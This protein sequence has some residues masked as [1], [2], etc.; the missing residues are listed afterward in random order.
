VLSADAVGY[1]R[2][3]GEDE[4]ATIAA[5]GAARARFRER[6]AGRAGRVVD[7]AGDNVL[8]VFDSVIEALRAAI[9]I[10]EDLGR[11]EENVPEPRRMRFRIG[12]NAGEIVEEEDGSVYGDG[13]N[14]A[15]RLQALAEP[16]GIC[17]AEVVAAQ[18]RNKL[19]VR[20]ESLGEQ[21]VKNIAEPIRPHRVI[22]SESP[23]V[24]ASSALSL[25]AKPSIA[26]LPFVNMS[27][28]PE[29]EYFSDGIS[30]DL[31]TALSRIRWFFVVARNSSFAYKSARIDVKQVGRELGVRYVLEGS[32]RKSGSR[33]RIT[34]QPIDASSG[35]H[36]WAERYDR[37]LADV[38]SL[39]DEITNRISAAIEP[40]LARAEVERSRRKAPE[41]LDAWDFYQR[42][43]W[44]LWQFTARDNVLARGFFERAT[45]L[46]SGFSTFFAALALSRLLDHTLGYRPESERSVDAALEAA[47]RAV[48]LD[49]KDPGAHSALGRTYSVLGQ[50]DEGIAELR[51]ALQLNPSMALARYGLGVALVLSGRAKEAV[52]EFDAAQRLSP[53]DV[54]LWNFSMWRAWAHLSLGDFEHAIEDASFSVRQPMAAFPA[55]GTLASAL[56]HAGR[57]EEARSA[58]AKT[59][60]LEPRFSS[61]QFFESVWPNADPRLLQRIYDGLRKLDPTIPDPRAIIA[62]RSRT[63]S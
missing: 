47:R 30:E 23:A 22:S 41:N 46:D 63:R 40:E 60:E 9:E 10:Q 49:E 8:A 53:H 35:N 31:I 1:S 56:A 17:A 21:R 33:V 61:P 48:A 39:Q 37:E 25:P 51:R 19:P 20:F 6:I 52:S 32:V 12:V 5:L 26:V 18:V 45:E 11:L 44:H 55:W 34:A 16:G 28:D 43:V 57:L 62:A 36:V 2:L 15:A 14:V 4:D 7:T 27:G 24:P 54:F 13:V 3:M 58:L 50:H 59:L 42:G 29:Q 38:F